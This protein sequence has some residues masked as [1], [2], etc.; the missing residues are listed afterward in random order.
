[1]AKQQ[2]KN[3][4]ILYCST[5]LTFG[6]EQKQLSLILRYLNR[7]RFTP[8]LCS[9]RSYG[10]LDETITNSGI[11]LLCLKVEN[12]YNIVGAIRALRR[13]IK[14]NKIDLVHVGVFGPQFPALIAAMS[15]RTPSV[16]VLQSTFNLAERSRSVGGISLAA[17]FKNRLLYAAMSLLARAANIHFVALSGAVKES[18]VKDMHLP[19]KNITVIPLGLL[20]EVFGGDITIETQTAGENLGIKGAYPVLLNVAR[21]S[22]VKGQQDL[23]KMMPMVLQRFPSAK[24]I[25]AGD[26]PLMD[27]LKKVRKDLGLEKQVLLLGQRNDIVSLLKVCDVFVF[28]SFYEGLPGAVVEAMAAGKPVVAFDLPSLKELVI[29]GRTGRLIPGRDTTAFSQAI[30][31]LSDDRANMTAMSRQAQQLVKDNFDIRNNIKELEK[32]YE[33][34]LDPQ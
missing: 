11:P 5:A 16:A 7:E 25:I 28:S 26:G 34:T 32:L 19:A 6:G 14:E 22:P 21:L 1:M 20:P 10:Y 13:A 3:H 8:T 23:I 4:R 33:K 18:A 27:D 29:E 9:I 15:T 31:Q 24:L 2:S 30:I 12:K 17:N